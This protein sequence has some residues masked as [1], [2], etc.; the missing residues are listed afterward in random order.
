MTRKRDWA[1][2]VSAIV[3]AAVALAVV[4][5]VA[6]MLSN[7]F[8]RPDDMFAKGL[9]LIPARPTL[10]NFRVAW[11]EYAVPRWFVNSVG[12]TVGTTFLQMAIY[13]LGAYGLVF[14]EFRGKNFWFLFFVA[15]MIVPF[16]A[17]MIPNYI[18]VSKAGLLNTWSAVILPSVASAF[19]IFLLRQSFM[20]FPKAIN[21]AALLEGAGTWR[22]LWTIV[23]PVSKAPI[24]ALAIVSF[25][26]AWNLYFW[27]LLVMS[28]PA[29][30]TL[31]IGLQQFIDYEMGSRWGPFMA[32]A[33]LACLPTL[34]LY[35]L[36]QRQIISTYANSGLKG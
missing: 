8:K 33:T 21:E 22:I 30:Q 14:F 1:S 31:S 34:V 13:I 17:T 18:L 19:G 11:N 6:V 29:S 4:F 36:M 20:T 7:S 32:T 12:T 25:I 5:P 26:D 27:P 3:L 16:Q 28:E 35:L 15:S 2:L 23:V 9:N 24:A 10:D